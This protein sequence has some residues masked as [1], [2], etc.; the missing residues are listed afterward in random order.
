MHEPREAVL[1]LKPTSRGTYPFQGPTR[2]S[3]YLSAKPDE[4]NC[5]SHQG[6]VGGNAEWY[7]GAGLA[8]SMPVKE[9]FSVEQDSGNFSAV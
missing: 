1:L 3:L 6:V 4:G 9:I 2:E 8:I 5:K 7:Q